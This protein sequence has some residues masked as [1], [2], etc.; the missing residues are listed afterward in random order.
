VPPTV[1]RRLLRLA[2]SASSNAPN[3]EAARARNTNAMTPTT[4]GLPSAE[5]KPLP[6]IAETTPIGVNRH[7]MPST[8]VSD[9]RAPCQRLLAS[10][11]PKTETVIA[12][13]G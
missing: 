3:R 8:N 4:Q 10:L 9:R 12:I 11:A 6:V 13:I 7:T 5:P 1:E 2:G